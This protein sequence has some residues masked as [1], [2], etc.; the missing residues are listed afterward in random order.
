MRFL[1]H[2]KIPV[3]AGNRAIAAGTL[4][5]DLQ[6]L[7][8]DL[9]PEAAYFF[10]HDG[11]RSSMLIVNISD[12]S[13]IPSVAEPFFLKMNAEVRLHPVMTAEDLGKAGLDNLAQKWG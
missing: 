5:K 12:A 7:L 9:K 10:E 4:S 2:A 11:C 6:T 1:L 8:A 3:E 13:Q